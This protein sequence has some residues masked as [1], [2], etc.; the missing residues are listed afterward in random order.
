MRRAL[1]ISGPAMAGGTPSA[2]GRA[3][4]EA[5]RFDGQRLPA[6]EREVVARGD[7]GLEQVRADQG[8]PIER[9]ALPRAPVGLD[10]AREHRGRQADEL[11]HD[12]CGL[13]RALAGAS[14]TLVKLDDELNELFDAPAEVAVRIF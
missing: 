12:G 13:A 9:L 6:G 14:V 3:V 7:E 10:Q 4:R 11:A 5:G 8:D 2:I 1:G